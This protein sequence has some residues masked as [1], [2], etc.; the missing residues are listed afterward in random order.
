M[1]SRL[2]LHFVGKINSRLVRN[3]LNNFNPLLSLHVISCSQG[4]FYVIL[5]GTS[6]NRGFDWIEWLQWLVLSLSPELRF[7]KVS[8][9]IFWNRFDTQVHSSQ[10]GIAGLYACVNDV[11]SGPNKPIPDYIGNAVCL[12]YMKGTCQLCCGKTDGNF[13]SIVYH[14]RNKLLRNRSVCNLFIVFVFVT[15]AS[16]T[17]LIAKHI[18]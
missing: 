3:F 7:T 16:S 15:R 17:Y 1:L 13:A 18:L 12:P 2:L 6:R 5:L 11:T 8:S 14:L 10:N 9:N 4:P